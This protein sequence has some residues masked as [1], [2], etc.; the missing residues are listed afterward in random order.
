[1]DCFAFNLLDNHTHF[2]VRVKDEKSLRHSI[3]LI[4]KQYWTKP[5]QAFTQVGAGEHLAGEI[6]ER[7]VNSFMASYAKGT[8]EL[9]ARKGGLFQ[10]PFRRSLIMSESHLQQAI[11]YVHANAQKHG[12]VKD[13]KEHP[14]TSYHE[15]LSGES[16]NVKA[17]FVL[18]FF[19]GKEMFIQTHARQVDYYYS[20]TFD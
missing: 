16:K 9:Y 4:A 12:I 17:D 15:I 10:S 20:S 5:M 3:S 19:G 13:F 2:V 7:Q 1:M 11:I 14:Y 18:D 8:N 6:I